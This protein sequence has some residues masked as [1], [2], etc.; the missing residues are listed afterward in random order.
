MRIADQCHLRPDRRRG[1]P[2]SRRHRASHA[3]PA[4]ER[5][6]LSGRN[7]TP[8]AGGVPADQR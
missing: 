4:T 1:E 8:A 3:L 6:A 7:A 5:R 2:R